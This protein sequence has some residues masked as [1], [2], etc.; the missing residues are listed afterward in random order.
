MAEENMNSELKKQTEKIAAG[1][2]EFEKKAD[3]QSILALIEFFHHDIW[4]VRRY[5]SQALVRCAHINPDTLEI[6]DGYLGKYGFKNEN[7][8]YWSLQTA[9]GIRVNN[10]AGCLMNWAVNESF[11]KNYM[12]HLIKALAK[13]NDT[14]SIS[15]LIEAL[16]NENW[17][18]KKEASA[19]LIAFGRNIIP[20]L[21]SAFSNEKIEIRTWISKIIGQILGK[22]AYPFFKNM[23]ASERKEMRY[24][25]I[26]ALSESD[27]PQAVAAIAAKAADPSWLIRIQTADILEKIGGP[28]LVYLKKNIEEGSSDDKFHSIKIIQKILKDKT[29]SVIRD[30]LNLDDTESKILMLSALAEQND[31]SVFN[32]LCDSLTDSNYLI[33]RHA[34]N[35]LI[36]SGGQVASKI[37]STFMRTQC[38]IMRYWFIEVLSAFDTRESFAAGTAIFNEASKR[39]KIQI[40][41]SISF[42]GDGGDN[43]IEELNRLKMIFLINAL[44]DSGYSVRN[45]A[46]NQLV[47][48]GRMKVIMD[49]CEIA[50]NDSLLMIREAGFEQRGNAHITE[51]IKSNAGAAQMALIKALSASGAASPAAAET[52]VKAAPTVSAAPAGPAGEVYDTHCRPGALTASGEQSY[53]IHETREYSLGIEE[54]LKQAVEKKASDI[55]FA[56]DYPPTFRINGHIEFQDY[57]QTLE[58][59]HIRHL[60]YQV[61]KPHVRQTFETNQELDTSYEI[62]GLARFRVNMYMDMHGIGM[63]FRVIPYEIPDL[64][65]LGVPAIIKTLA[66]KQKGL[67]LVTGPTGSGKSTTLAS[68]IN[69]INKNRK[70]HIITIEDPVEFLHKPILSKVT[71]RELNTSTRSF[72]GA[73][74]SSL[75]EDPDIILVGEMRDLE[76]IEMAITAAETGHLVLSTVHTSSAA[77]TIDRLI[78][79]FPAD[80]HSQV[81]AAL[82]EGL[83]AVVAQSLVAKKSGGMT[84]AFE[85]MT[86]TSAI[87][88]LIKEG[89]TTQIKDYMLAGKQYGMQILDDSLAE[90]MSRDEITFEAALAAS[91]NKDDFKK[92]YGSTQNAQQGARPANLKQG[93]DEDSLYGLKPK[94]PV[95]RPPVKK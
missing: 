66:G 7:D 92:R 56:T 5:A 52:G 20:Q 13:I 45:A 2:A 57:L 12:A 72:A 18:V 93:I 86:M 51:L 14:S 46:F 88:N 54:L 30:Y 3:R 62:K 59:A 32:L 22:D 61:L 39:Q 47:G 40:L 91:Y 23:L 4:A 71:Q 77:N 83:I 38:D 90:L 31:E 25:A 33:Q 65:S 85:I 60:A 82:T 11:P 67:V 70:A 19:A 26:C 53:H 68:M 89:K 75:R 35:L 48:F 87:G 16:G 43:K 10:A 50:L 8:V 15:F 73:L 64:D 21:Q 17:I 95:T 76:T 58:A 81:R 6:I 29:F 78:D 1:V 42:A 79:A 37:A 63:V 41:R 55:H 34:A 9:A 28:A 24:Y 74:R 49:S 69:Y 94:A 84:A 27:D 80:K 36:H 44:A